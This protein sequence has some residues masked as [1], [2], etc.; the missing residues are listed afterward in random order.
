LPCPLNHEFF[1]TII[2]L[3][4]VLT[5]ASLFHGLAQEENSDIHVSR[6]EENERRF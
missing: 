4:R 6:G 3:S 1:D 5:T 2:Y